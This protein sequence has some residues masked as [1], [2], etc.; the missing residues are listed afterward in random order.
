MQKL[1]AIAEDYRTVKNYVYARFGGVA[2]LPKLYPGYTIQNEMAKSGLRETLGMPSVY[3]Y[4]AVFEALGDLK[5]QWIQVKAQ[6][7]KAVGK[8]ENFTPED[9][10]YLRYVLKIRNCFAAILNYA[11]M[12]LEKGYEE[13]YKELASIVDT[14]RLDN[15]L[16]RQVRNHLKKLHADRAEGFSIVERA[17]RYGDHG[18]Y[19]STKESRKRMFVPLT[20]NNQY[21]RQ[22]YIKLHQETN[23]LEILVPIDVKVKRHED[24]K[25]QVGVSLG[26]FTMLT[27]DGGRTYGE[28]LGEYVTWQ[29]K[30]IEKETRSYQKNRQDNPGRKRYMEQKRRVD[31][32]QHAYINMEL[33][34]FLREEMPKVLYLPKL[35]GKNR[36]GRIKEYNRVANMWQRGYIRQRLLQKCREESVEVVEIFGKDISRECSQCEAMGTTKEGIFVCPECGLRMDRKVNAACNA[37]KWGSHKN[38]TVNKGRDSFD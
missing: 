37:K 12:E 13:K 4:L 11:P 10:H 16:R 34:R 19:L 25:N 26:I 23:D 20:D 36:G 35:P 1:Q 27:T 28:R 8:N 30:W 17:Y 29:S 24:Y 38:R 15:Y 31:E 21:S 2:S 5:N 18:I 33:N 3:F 14:H 6:V 9:A 32:G 7:S 22:L